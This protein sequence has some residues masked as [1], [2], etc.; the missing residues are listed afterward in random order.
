MRQR[1]LAIIAGVGVAFLGLGIAAAQTLGPNRMFYNPSFGQSFAPR[2]SGFGGGIQTGPSGNF[3]SAGRPGGATAFVAPWPPALPEPLPLLGPASAAQRV[4]Q[5][6][7]VPDSA[8]AASSVLTAVEPAAPAA[9]RV[10]AV[11]PPAVNP[12]AEQ[13]LAMPP[14]IEL[15]SAGGAINAATGSP[16]P[17]SRSPRLS[18]L[19][20]RIARDRGV[21]L[22]PRIDV[23]VGQSAAVIEGRVRSS[24]DRALLA[25]VLGLEPTVRT[26]AN[27]LAVGAY[28]PNS[29]PANGP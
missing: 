18:D 20:T 10:V 26:V 28:Q 6:G 4:L 21:L 2:P 16:S 9:P 3:L 27:R 19:L 22:S 15:P 13:R 23:Y 1:G 5:L 17:Y 24:S 25:N 14:G 8:I 29:T 12:P 7:P 11:A